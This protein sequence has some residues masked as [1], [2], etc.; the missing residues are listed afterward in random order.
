M[1]IVVKATV[2]A[3]YGMSTITQRHLSAKNRARRKRG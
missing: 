2:Y 3:M 1:Y